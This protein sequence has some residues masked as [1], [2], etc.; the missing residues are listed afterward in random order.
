MA[1]IPTGTKGYHITGTAGR[2][3]MVI[4]DQEK[5]ELRHVGRTCKP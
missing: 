5:T 1:K 2:G 3:C 4:D